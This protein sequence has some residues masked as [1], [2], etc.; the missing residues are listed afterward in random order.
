MTQTP[1]LA[2]RIL[3]IDADT[4]FEAPLRIGKNG[5]PFAA[6]S[7]AI[8]KNG[9]WIPSKP[10]FLLANSFKL[11]FK[12]LRL[13]LA[14]FDPGNA[15]PPAWPTMKDLGAWI[16]SDSPDQWIFHVLVSKGNE[17]AILGINQRFP[18]KPKIS[19][20]G[21]CMCL[22]MARERL[23]ILQEEINEFR[24]RKR[25]EGWHF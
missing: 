12:N 14:D 16:A 6:L 2:H 4:R 17:P 1:P 20:P 3:E 15:T 8:L 23:E 13:F 24:E 22:H 25:T 11:L 18:G 7:H 5:K 21:R 19:P 10:G 9:S